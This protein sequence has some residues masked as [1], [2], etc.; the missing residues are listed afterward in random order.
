MLL[1]GIGPE[2]QQ[3]LAD[4]RV[5]L[6]GC[7]ALGTVMADQLVRAGVGHLR[8]VD[9][10]IV[11]L[12]NLQRQT[13][14]DEDDVAQSLPK[15]IAAANRLKKINSSVIVE[16]IVADVHPGNIEEL[17]STQDSG[18]RSGFKTGF[19]LWHGRPAH[20]FPMV[21]RSQHGRAAHATEVL[22]PLLSTQH[23]DLI[24]D[25]TDNLETRYLINDVAIKGGI[26]WVYGGAVGY[27]GRVMGVFP[28][29]SPCL[30]CL[31]PNPPAPGEL[32][33]CDT[34]GVLGP[35]TGVVGSLQ[36]A[37]A[38]K[39]LTGQAAVVPHELMTLD[40]WSNRICSMSLTLGRNEDC[41]VCVHRRFQ[42]L[43]SQSGPGATSLCGRNAVQVRP[44]RL[45][46]LD[47]NALAA[48]L[49]G[50]GQVQSTP[51]FIRCVLHDP[52][53]LSL[54]IFPDGRVLVHGTG[55]LARARSVCAR[56]V[57]S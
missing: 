26:P 33:T 5:L 30:F 13:L 9:R 35:L 55:D 39:I 16:P 52:R 54:T 12:T 25:G 56:F 45:H 17:L 32:P 50:F 29:V 40:L 27:E 31:F 6:I 41:P 53:E 11:E 34:A 22:K 3:K 7:G 47:L 10:D 18:L 28:G 1:P 14:F 21:F 43:D 2:G 15:A 42:F 38:L 4:A 37:L 20:A 46:H 23:F 49:Q 8:L 19:L 36:A 44:S 51:Y 24:L 57:G 48:R